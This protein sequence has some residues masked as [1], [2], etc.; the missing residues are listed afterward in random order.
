MRS[1]SKTV[2]LCAGART[3]IGHFA[4][5]LADLPPAA[6]MRLAVKAV[7]ESARLDPAAVDGLLVGWVGQTFSAPNIAR[8]VLLESGLPE[9]A[10]S[11]TV[12]NNCLSSL[13]AACEAARRI[14]AGEGSLYIVGGTESMSRLPYTIEGSRAERCLRSLAAVREKWPTLWDDP[15]ASIVDAME[16]GLTDPVRKVGMAATA[17]I[18]AQVYGIGRDEQDRYARESFRRTLAAWDRGFYASHV[19]PAV[20][21]GKRLLEKDE[22]PRLREELPAKPRL[23]AKAPP[24]FDS[25]AYPFKRFFDDYGGFMGGLAYAPDR[26]RATVTPFNSCGRSDG[27]SALIVAEAGRA[28]ELGL[29]ILAEL[30]SWGYVGNDPAFMGVSPAL[31]APLALERA[32]VSFAQLDRI[33]LHEPFAA[34]VLS[35]F[36]LGRDKYGCDWAAKDAAGALNPNGGSI[37]LGH[38]LGATGTRLLL[39]LLYSLREDPGARL[40]MAAACAGGG[41]GGAVIV[42]KR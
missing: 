40:G 3:P 13:E 22:Y 26:S 17:E 11:L 14:L 28:R 10:Q 33:E 4:R 15:A 8:V 34:T 38:P 18:C 21:D 25:T 39:N 12:Q 7:L 20:K 37:A 27:A 36:K 16:E 6:L 29:T 2:V 32:G 31:A 30:L 5:G 1:A 9:K 41:T 19:V 42:A 24:L 23:F 35:I